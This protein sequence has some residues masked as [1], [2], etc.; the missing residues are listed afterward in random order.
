MDSENN[1]KSENY[2]SD[3][4]INTIW[5]FFRTKLSDRTQKEYFAVIKNFSKL[6]G[7]DPLKINREAVSQ[8]TD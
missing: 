8:Y 5:I 4:F 7:R 1:I 2:L 3:E 6:T